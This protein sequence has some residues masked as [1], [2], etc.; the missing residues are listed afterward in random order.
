MISK[1]IVRPARGAPR[2]RSVIL[3]GLLVGVTASLCGLAVVAG[4]A[5]AKHCQRCE[6][7]YS[8]PSAGA[9]SDN[10]ETGGIASAPAWS[11]SE[12]IAAS[13]PT[14][15]QLVLAA[16]GSTAGDGVRSTWVR[17]TL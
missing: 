8:T 7:K 11:T 5:S 3:R 16:L 2:T 15:G 14:R 6:D 4:P 1:T 10:R 17:K 12:K 13:D 9:V